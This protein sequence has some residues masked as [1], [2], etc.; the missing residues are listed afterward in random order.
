MIPRKNRFH[1][2]GSLNHVYR[3]GATVR[4]PLFSLKATPNPRRKSYRLAVVVSR[5][6]NKSAVARNR[7]RRRLYEAVRAQADR[8]TQPQDIVITV[9]QPSLLDESPKTLAIQVEKQLS[10][11]GILPKRNTH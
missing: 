5:K 9:F 4:G 11:A 3:Q 1:G 2:Y 8:I 6:V 7:M 10:D